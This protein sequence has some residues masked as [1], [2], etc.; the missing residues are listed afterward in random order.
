[1][2]FPD[3]LAGLALAVTLACSA[4]AASPEAT[5][6]EIA[7]ALQERLP[8]VAAQDYRLGAAALDAE[9]RR[10]LDENATA[11]AST[12]AAGKDL[13]TR[14]F[15]NGRTL[16]GCFPNGGRRV[17]AAYPQFDPRLKRV[18]TLEMAINQCLKAH[19]EALYDHAD[20]RTMG[21]VMAY[22]RSLADGQKVAVRVPP[23]AEERF[24]Q[25]RRLYQSRLG[26]RNYA[27]A[28]CHVQGAGRRFG[29]VP[30][31][32][33]IGQA[34]H[35]PVIRKGEPV[36]LQERMRECLELMGAAPFPAG[37]EELN[38][39]EYFLTYLSNGLPMAANAWRP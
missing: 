8:G 30:L 27:C 1:M 26:Q 31:S 7:T 35:W 33:A 20:A 36:T 11:G 10:A 25:G 28:S 24:E 29:E 23:A 9:L 13:W 21:T 17:A 32:P 39:L 34:T 14:K 3:R 16:S 12:L 18:I 6:A 38:N 4:Q 37:S 15:K 19:G 2:R 5:R 22:L